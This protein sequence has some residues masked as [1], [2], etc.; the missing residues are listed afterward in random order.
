MFDKGHHRCCNGVQG[1]GFAE[2]VR[3]LLMFFIHFRWSEAGVW[4]EAG[5][6][7]GW[8]GLIVKIV[9]MFTVWLWFMRVR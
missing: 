1:W 5:W 2:K 4:S 8:G 6:H 9:F 3:S 7:C